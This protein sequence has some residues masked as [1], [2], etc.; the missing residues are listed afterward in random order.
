M[1]VSVKR[2]RETPT[3]TNTS[4]EHGLD[5]LNGLNGPRTRS[6]GLE[7]PEPLERPFLLERLEQLEQMF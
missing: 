2:D 5:V 7:R 4:H 1:I 3:S 6:G